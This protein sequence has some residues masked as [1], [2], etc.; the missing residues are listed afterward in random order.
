MFRRNDK[1]LCAGRA[2]R[3]ASFWGARRALRSLQTSSL[4]ETA[5]LVP[6]NFESIIVVSAR[7]SVS[8]STCSQQQNLRSPDPLGVNDN[9]HFDS[10]C[11]DRNGC[12]SAQIL[13]SAPIPCMWLV[14]PPLYLPISHGLDHTTFHHFLHEQIAACPAQLDTW[15]SRRLRH[16]RQRC[17]PSTQ[18]SRSCTFV[19]LTRVNRWVTGIKQ[20]SVRRSVTQG[21]RSRYVSPVRNAHDARVGQTS[22]ARHGD[23]LHLC[24]TV[25]RLAGRAARTAWLEVQCASV[26]HVQTRLSTVSADGWPAHSR[27][28]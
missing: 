19:R 9:A 13:G 20:C 3:S 24:S 2:R 15:H 10:L 7:T 6:N 18:P 23:L 21:T 16:S 4:R 5:S 27:R 25:A 12:G 8:D 28:V 1:S 22:S 11:P 14:M 17:Y 26:P